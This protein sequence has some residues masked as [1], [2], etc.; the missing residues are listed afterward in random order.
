VHLNRAVVLLSGGIDSCVTAIVAGQSYEL[1]TLHIN[2]GQKTEQRELLSSR[3]ISDFL[4]AKQ[5][6][7]VDLSH[8][9]QIGGS[10]LTSA[11]MELEHDVPQ[12]IPLSYVPFRNAQLLAVA[13]SWAEVI[14]SSYIF[15][16][17]T[18]ED[19]S[20]YPDTTKEFFA[21][22]NKVVEVGTRPQTHIQILTPLINLKKSEVIRQGWELGAPLHLTWSCYHNSISPCGVCLSCVRRLQAFAEA[23]IRDPIEYADRHP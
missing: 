23:G 13:V 10:S 18:R 7:E 19:G 15:I 14:G 5:R 22:F 1:A 17:A 21:E 4:G 9:K 6:L 3:L 11:Q 8:L 20:H 2:Y 16:G 12:G